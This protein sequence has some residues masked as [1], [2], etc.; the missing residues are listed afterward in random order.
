M[1]GFTTAILNDSL[2]KRVKNIKNVSFPYYMNYI[3]KNMCP[4]FK[5]TSSGYAHK[6]LRYLHKS[7]RIWR[8]FRKELSVK[9][10]A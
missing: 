3:R 5:S 1:L 2:R 4:N 10:S 7:L 9:V 6:E 8:G